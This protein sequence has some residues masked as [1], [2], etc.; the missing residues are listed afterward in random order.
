MDLLEAQGAG[1]GLR[2]FGTNTDHGHRFNRRVVIDAIRVHGP[3]SRADIARRTGLSPQTI[4]NIVDLLQD[5]NLIR[6]E[7]RPATGRGQPPIDLL[8]NPNGG[9]TVGVSFDQ[10]QL[11]AVITNL[12]GEIKG[13]TSM[14]LEASP[15]A[16]VLPLI[17]AT[18]HSLIG[19]ARI[20]PEEVWGVGVVMPAV[21]DNGALVSLGPIVVP[22][23]E[24]FALLKRLEERLS[25]PVHVDNDAT[26]AAVGEKLYGVGRELSD[27]FYIFIG[28]G[29]GAGVISEG[30]PFRGG[31]GN[32]GEIGHLVTVPDGR[33]CPCGNRGCLERYLGL[34]SAQS[35]L[36]GI[37][38]RA[39]PVDEQRILQAFRE[40]DPAIGQWLDEAAAQLRLATVVVE[41]LFD[42]QAT[43]VGGTIPE[44]MIDALLSR[45][46]PLPRSLTSRRGEQ[47]PRL[48]KAQSGLETPALG[49]AAL[50]AFDNITPDVSLLFKQGFIP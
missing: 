41:N 10:R 18:V 28:A 8:I 20:P 6:E 38:E 1:T 11:V 5:S 16:V 27:F 30:R 39:E 25:I 50:A 42:P 23:W 36:T 40:D 33:P 24:N 49:A 12:A 4:S 44:P 46:T 37:P 45:A 43:V 34:A 2:V 29:I 3:V 15:P 13:Q 35:A 47:S 7:P 32:A 21:F 19:K 26:A 9:H 17:E 22:E 14:A 48:I 31:H